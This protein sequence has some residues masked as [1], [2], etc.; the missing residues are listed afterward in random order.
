MIATDNAT[1]VAYI[2]E[3]GRTHS[4]TLLCLVLDL[5]LWLQTQDIVIRAG[6]IPG[7]LNVIADHLFW[8]NQ[9]KPVE[10]PPQNNDPDALSQDWQGRSIFMFPRFP[11]LSKVIQKLRTTQESEVI[12]IAPWWPHNRGFHIYY[13]F[14]WTTLSSFH[15]TGT[16][17]H[18]RDM[19]WIASRTICMLGGLEHYQA[20]G[21]SKR[22]L[23]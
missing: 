17:F 3:Q 5:F 2:N 9:P 20:A 11:L 18:N 10:S 12:L 1:V 22:S 19:S 14:V 7:C 4:H 15:T 21:F 23:D 6:H 16:Y 13:V 8:P